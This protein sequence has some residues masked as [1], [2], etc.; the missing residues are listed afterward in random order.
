VVDSEEKE[1]LRQQ[2][3]AFSIQDNQRPEEGGHSQV[4]CLSQDQA[5]GLSEE[6]ASAI[7][8]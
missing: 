2:R 1:R 3:L 6:A 4:P 7:S 5:E 8:L